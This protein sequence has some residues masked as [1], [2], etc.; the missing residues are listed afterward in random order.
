MKI[1]NSLFIYFQIIECHKS[2]F[3]AICRRS[4]T[5]NLV[6]FLEKNELSPFS[7]KLGKMILINQKN[8]SLQTFI[9]LELSMTRYN[10]KRLI[11]FGKLVN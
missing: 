7:H 11:R 4:L 6:F 8:S 2:I 1:E 5:L 10:Q 9:L 3:H